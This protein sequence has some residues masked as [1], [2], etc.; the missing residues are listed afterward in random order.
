VVAASGS[1]VLVAWTQQTGDE[2][3]IRLRRIE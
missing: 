2:S 3:V 1:G